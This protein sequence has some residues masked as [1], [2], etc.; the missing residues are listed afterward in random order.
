MPRTSPMFKLH[1]SNKDLVRKKLED[2]R[3]IK[4]GHWLWTGNTNQ[5]GYG[6][7]EIT[8]RGYTVHRLS[9]YVYTENFD[10]NNKSIQTLHRLECLHKNCFN[11]DHLYPGTEKDNHKDTEIIFKLN[12]PYFSCGHPR[13]EENIY[14]INR[15]ATPRHV[16]TK[17]SMCRTCY[18]AYI[19]PGCE[20]LK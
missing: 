17:N 14:Y 3:W 1:I 15:K 2:N 19:H 5:K 7:I 10:I 13:V 16:A 12:N 9:L 6:I 20:K 18:T 11:P 8:S 4:D